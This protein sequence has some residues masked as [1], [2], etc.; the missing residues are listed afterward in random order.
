[1]I[2]IVLCTIDCITFSFIWDSQKWIR[3]VEWGDIIINN[4]SK[5]P[6]AN[7]IAQC[8]SKGHSF[9]PNLDDKE[10]DG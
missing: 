9:A 6:I 1:M 10:S 2:G 8:L 7:V 5:D 4:V 3:I